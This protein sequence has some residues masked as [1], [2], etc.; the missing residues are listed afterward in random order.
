[1]EFLSSNIKYLRKTH[2]LTTAGLAKKCEVQ[3]K[4]I[5]AL[6]KEP[7]KTPISLVM[8][9]VDFFNTSLHALVSTDL[10]VRSKTTGSI[11]LLVLDIDGVLTD[12]GMYYAEDG[13]EYKK[14]N[15]K[16]GLAIRRLIKKGVQVAFLSNG[17]NAKLITNR[18][19]LLGVQKVYVGTEEKETVLNKWLKELNITYKNIAYVGDDLNDLAVI[20]KAGFSACPSDAIENIRQKVSVVLSRKGGDAC[21][22]ELIDLYF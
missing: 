8:L 5:V 21:V 6:E 9:L 22:R 1:M 10:R 14:F 16:D 12:G 20:K 18:A 17:I 13:N 2:R 11:K 3:E 15:S 19:K 4:K 7:G